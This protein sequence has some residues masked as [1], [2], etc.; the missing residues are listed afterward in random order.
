MRLDSGT[1]SSSSAVLPGQS[2]HTA[3]GTHRLHYD[4]SVAQV[5][6]QVAEALDYAHREGVIHRDIKPSNLLLDTESRV[7]ITDFGLARTEGDA[8]THTGDIIGTL[9]YMAPERFRGWSDP[10]SDVYS[11]G[12]TLYE[13]LLLRPAF[14]T[15]DRLELIRR[16]TH[17]EPARPRTLDPRI[18]RDLETIVLKAIDKEPSRRYQTAAELAA[19]LR[20][21]L[22]DEPIRARRVGPWERAWRWARRRPAAAA[23]VLMS[24]LA[25]LALVGVVVRTLDYQRL[26]VA[27]AQIEQARQAEAVQ[28][29]RAERYQ[30]LHH[31]G[32]VHAGWRDG[33]L[34]Q[35]ERLLEECPPDQRHWEWNYLARLCRASLFTFNGHTT[36]VFDAAYSP[37]GTR[38]A[39]AG[40][41]GK[42]MIW[43]PWT[44]A[45]NRILPGRKGIDQRL[46]F[47]PDG[48]RLAVAC[49]DDIVILW[50]PETGEKVHTLAPHGGVVGMGYSPDGARLVTIGRVDGDLRRGSTV[51]VWDARTGLEI[52]QLPGLTN[53]YSRVS[54]SPDGTRIVLVRGDGLK[55]WDATTY[56][57]IRDF[58]PS[59]AL[60]HDIEA[61]RVAFSPDGRRAAAATLN[62]GV[63]VWD[64][65]TFEP[66][67]L[68][69]HTS[70]VLGVAFSPD[71]T[72]LAS[73]GLDGTVRVWDAATGEQV[74]SLKGHTNGVLSVAYSPDGSHL[75][76]AGHDRKVMVWDANT[77]PEA[78][79]IRGAWGRVALSPDGS[80][81][82]SLIR[83][84]GVATFDVTT[85][86]FIRTLPGS[87]V[88][89][90][91]VYHPGGA[92]IARGGQGG[93]VKLWD[94]ESGRKDIPALEPSPRVVRGATSR[95]DNAPEVR[96]LAFDSDGK[97]LAAV[98][99]DQSVTVWDMTTRQVLFE[100]PG[101]GRRLQNHWL[102]CIVFSPDGRWLALG[103]GSGA[104][105]VWDASTG[106]AAFTLP[107]NTQRVL[108]LAFHPDPGRPL[109]ASASEDD[110]TVKIW[111]M[112]TRGERQILRGH[113]APVHSLVFSS[114]G[115]R[116]ITASWDNTVKLWDVE[117]GLVVLTLRGHLDS[118]MDVAISRDHD[119]IATTS[120]D[121][122]VKIWD[123]R[124]WT[125][126]SA[127]ERE[128]KGQLDFLF[129]RPL[130]RADVVEYL[131][132]SR[133]I[134]PRARRLALDLVGR[135][136]EQT[137][138][139]SYHRASRAAVLQ[140][141]LNPFQCRF[142][143]LQAA[144]ACRLA[145][146]RGAYRATLGAAQYRAGRF[147]EAV[148]TLE[149]AERLAELSPADLAFLA[150]AQHRLGEPN[151]A[152]ASLARL[153]AI[154]AQPGGPKD[155][156]TLALWREAE[157]AVS[158]SS[159]E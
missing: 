96:Y 50:D 87:T 122:T 137:D 151:R 159:E 31:I 73:A 111:D 89:S 107:G 28:L 116:L 36:S 78:L 140:R 1:S 101:E 9:R 80:Q 72:R 24:G 88:P 106:K 85:G 138:P 99:D 81:L 16:I 58:D 118:T 84:A 12:L 57:L 134:R 20:R 56:T 129:A 43:D 98:F 154:V 66:R 148:A 127:A 67:R 74:L 27:N 121:N 48:S 37:D 83:G 115:R 133:A 100:V 132:G 64:L 124:P 29:Q 26:Q 18:P 54:F 110:G 126:D 112:T 35:A 41:D 86:Q 103:N 8:L 68:E 97:R 157:R 21:F 70:N 59:T 155:P 136:H 38:I 69:G 5:G 10:R 139:E 52:T 108:G 44:G 152:R 153:R 14:T 60:G 23:L 91:I 149:Q 22:A 104:V 3:T 15:S 119:R 114:D 141:F 63:V 93:V 75:V 42:V 46:A 79:T 105:S 92:L 158:S 32:L 123:G 61:V 6:V 25:A 131:R 117:T 147:A 113:A 142:A 65:E 150:L 34:N 71:G 90:K 30:Y 76:T 33:E 135:Y 130:S 125:E 40:E 39:S 45:I 143:L 53:D 128:A 13:M 11:L 17:E 120:W 77:D 156:E 146:D 7:W 82:T 2:E 102:L 4:R 109:L 62:R 95:P 144:H 145:P 49:Q 94:V 19:D 47:S 51:H 55:V